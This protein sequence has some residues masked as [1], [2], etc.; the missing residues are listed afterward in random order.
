MTTYSQKPREVERN[1][2]LIDADGLVLGRLASIVAMR[3]RGKHK[4]TFTPHV[5]C[6]D[7][8]III[9]A[10]KVGLTG[11]KRADKT[12]YWHT[13][14]PGGIKSR[15]AEK[16]LDGNQ[17]ERVMIKAVERMI[18]RNRLG[19]QQMKKLHVYAG[20]EH[21]HQAQNPQLL[22]VAGMNSKNLVNRASSANESA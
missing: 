22:D 5:D 2:Y 1:W 7:N 9:N 15:S 11:N 17:P 21:P 19:R 12:Y 4:T 13:G 16:I 10:A 3:L 18:T 8:I 20:P 14:Y 6:G